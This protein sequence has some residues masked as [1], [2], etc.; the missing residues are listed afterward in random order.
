MNWLKKRRMSLNYTQEEM[1]D[2]INVSKRQYIRY[3]NNERPIGKMELDTF[4]LLAQPLH[5]SKR[6]MLDL[7]E[8]NK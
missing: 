2:L 8:D 6:Y 3:E 1:A 5:F 4:L 7:Y